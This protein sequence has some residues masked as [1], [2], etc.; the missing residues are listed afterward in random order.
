[1]KIMPSFLF[2]PREEFTSPPD[3]TPCIPLSESSALTL[4]FPYWLALSQFTAR[5]ILLQGQRIKDFAAI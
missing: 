3:K 5:Y 4:N 1:M 2:F